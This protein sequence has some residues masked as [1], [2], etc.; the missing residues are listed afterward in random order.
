MQTNHKT[1]KHPGLRS[2][3]FLDL[4]TTAPS[5][6]SY[7]ERL[8]S[9]SSSSTSNIAA[10]KNTE[11]KAMTSSKVDASIPQPPPKLQVD[12]VH[13]PSAK[14]KLIAK[15]KETPFVPIGEYISCPLQLHT[16]HQL[17][18]WAI[19]P[20]PARADVQPFACDVIA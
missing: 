11:K 12:D 8:L 2:P 17:S 6:A 7:K 14:E 15:S 1:L 18:Y 9:L 13:L 4:C 3:G 10:T 16:S 20:W 19:C 5:A